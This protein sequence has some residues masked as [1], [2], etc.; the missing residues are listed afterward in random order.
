MNGVRVCEHSYDMPDLLEPGDEI[1]VMLDW[2]PL[3]ED[4]AIYSTMQKVI[5]IQRVG[6]PIQ[7]HER[8][9]L[10]LEARAA[11]HDDLST[12]FTELALELRSDRP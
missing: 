5:V 1:L 8:W 10:D 2:P 12:W 9:K 4:P 6:K 11:Q 3:G 7:V